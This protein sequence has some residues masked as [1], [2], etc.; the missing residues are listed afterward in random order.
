MHERGVYVSSSFYTSTLE[1][2]KWLFAHELM[3]HAGGLS[4]IGEVNNLMGDWTGTNLRFRQLPQFYKAE[5]S[6]SQ[7]NRIVR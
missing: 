5:E 2:V 3:H 4:D 1:R 6:E 7:W